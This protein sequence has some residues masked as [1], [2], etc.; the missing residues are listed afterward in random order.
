MFSYTCP[1]CGKV[2][3]VER[4]S[5]VRTYCSY[6]C[7]NTGRQRHGDTTCSTISSKRVHPRGFDNLV[8]G[9]CRQARED[10]MKYPPGS[11]FRVSAEQF[12]RSDYFAALTELDGEAILHDLAK[13]YNRRE[14]I[15]EQCE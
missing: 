10:Y 8:A 14:K 1:V 13:L 11:Y 5:Q 4:R 12:F 3:E 7:S 6:A 15:N 2:K 9:M